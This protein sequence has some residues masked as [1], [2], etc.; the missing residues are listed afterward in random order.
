MVDELRAGGKEGSSGKLVE[1]GKEKVNHTKLDNE[2]GEDMVKN[3]D[4]VEK[5]FECRASGTR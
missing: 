1:V 4:H 5:G 3:E 2:W